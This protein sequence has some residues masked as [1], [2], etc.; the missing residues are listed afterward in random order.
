MALHIT[1]NKIAIN[2]DICLPLSL[3]ILCFYSIWTRNNLIRI[4]ILETQFCGS[5][6]I[7]FLSGFWLKVSDPNGSGSAILWRPND[8]VSERIQK[9]KSTFFS[10]NCCR[11][12]S[13][14]LA[15]VDAV[16]CLSKQKWPFYMK[17]QEIVVKVVLIIEKCKIVQDKYRYIFMPY[18]NQYRAFAIN[19]SRLQ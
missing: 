4:R 2:D 1:L 9:M 18:H 5:E 11:T 13:S 3:F 8:D 19:E 12:I 17:I 15:V 10:A 6:I 16:R 7:N 14:M